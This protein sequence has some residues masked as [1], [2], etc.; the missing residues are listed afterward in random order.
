MEHTYW[1]K[2]EELNAWVRILAYFEE[3]IDNDKFSNFYSKNIS[4]LINHP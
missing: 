1:P 3:D 4:E 2:K